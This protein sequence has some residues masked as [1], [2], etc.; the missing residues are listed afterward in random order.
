MLASLLSN[1][2]MMAIGYSRPLFSHFL[3]DGKVTLKLCSRNVLTK[4]K[5][6]KEKNM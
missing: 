6:V 2:K 1:L 3:N 4:M 5:T